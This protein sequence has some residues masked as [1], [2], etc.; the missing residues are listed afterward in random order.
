MFN[1]KNVC[2]ILLILL[3]FS[4]NFFL[5]QNQQLK[6]NV[7]WREPKAIEFEGNDFLIPDF[8]GAEL[9]HGRPVL[10]RSVKL[11][12]ASHKIELVNYS[13]A[14]STK[15]DLNFLNELDVEVSDQLQC[16]FQVTEAG[17]ENFAVVHLF[18]FIRENNVLKRINSIEFEILTVPQLVNTQ[19][20][21]FALTSVLKE[22][23]GTWFKISVKN[24]AIYKIDKAFL[25]SCGINTNGLNPDHINIYGNGD[26]KL[27]ELNSI[28]RTDD[29]AKNAIYIQGDS[30]GS[31]DDGDYILFYGWGPHRWSPTGAT[32]FEQTRNV[33]SD[34]SCYFININTND[35]PLRIENLQESAGPATH[36]ITSYSYFDIYENDLVSLVK[37]GQRW[38]GELFDT[39]L[40][41]TFNFSV[42]N[43]VSSFAA[44]FKLAIGTNARTS[45]GTLQRY[46][47]NG[48]LLEESNLPAVSIDY[49]RDVHSL[50]WTN[51]TSSMAFKINI[52]RNNPN[53]LV[54]LDRI[55]LNA[56]RN[57]VF[58]GSQ[59]KF[60]DLTSFGTGNIGEFQISSFPSSGFVWDI[61]NRHHP[62]KIEG[63]SLSMGV[64]TFNQEIDTL[65]EFCVSN[66]LSFQIPD[67]VGAVA[68]QDL[69]ALPQAELLIVT[70]KD[71][72][73]QA[74]RLAD[75]H[76]G[77][78]LTVNV[79]TTE[80]VFNEFSS[81]AVDATAIR[82]FAKMFYDRGISIPE[83]RLRNLLLF[84]DGTFDPKN[85]VAN[86]NYFIPT[87]QVELSE[88]HIGAMVTDD[89]FALLSDSDGIGATDM[90]D[91]GVGRLLISDNNIARQQ[92][93]KIQHYMKNGSNL[94]NTTTTNCCC[95][96]NGNSTTFGDWRLNYV[97]IADDEEGGYFIHQDTEPQYDTVS[98]Y[99]PEMNC[100][101]LYTDA[102]VQAT[103]AGGQRY[104]DVFEA[105]TNRVER[106]ALVVNYVGHGGE[107]GLAEE[108][109]VTI[110]QVQGWQNIDRLNVFVSAT[111]EFTKYD[112]PSRV[113][114]GE[115]VSLN[116][117]GGAIV[118]MT[119]SRSVYFGVNTITGKRFFQ[120]VFKRDAEDR[121]REFG[122]I[123]MLTKNGSGS[124]DNKRSF[125][126]IG[127]PALRIALPEM[128]IVTDSINGLSPS[129][130]ID[131]LQAL[132]KVTIKGHIEDFNGNPI[133]DFNG[134][135]SPSV[136]DKPK[137]QNTLGQD[138]NSPVIPFRVQR[139]IVYK[140]KSSVTNGYFEF[141]FVVPKDI[142]L[143]F[144]NGKISYYGENG[145]F[146]ASGSD[147]TFI[148][149]GI[150]P[151]GVND[152]IGPDITLYLNENNFVNGGITDETPMLV[153]E[154][155]DE[156]G[157]NTVGNGIG[158][159]LTAVID[160]NSA[161]PIV[162]NE[163]YVADLDSYQSGSVRYTLPQLTKGKHTLTLKVWDVNNNSSE[164]TIDFIVQEKETI[165]LDH[166]LNYPNPFTTYTEF[167]FEHNQVCSE[168]E[169]QVQIMTVSGKLV[170]TINQ[171]VNTQGFRSAGIPW[172][173]K[174]DFG[175]QLAKGVY[176]Y[177]IK[178][179]TPEGEIAEKLEK[180]VLLK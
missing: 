105:I 97:Q 1:L 25:E 130:I 108:R 49:V 117:Y 33:Y 171:T 63:S 4:N 135:L 144:G 167:F 8:E 68:Y 57:L 53:V 51:P 66:G 139:N 34:V 67:R 102:Y 179:K 145:D 124:S 163:Y 149:G 123:M 151:N 101:K 142:N 61:T 46:T 136:F 140:G 28:S 78:G 32:G 47:V 104:P 77:E 69:H 166:V 122:E 137:I 154:L 90:M 155:F 65:R 24:D 168:L 18:P 178:V 6:L 30:D 26:G 146:D 153:A 138:P 89:Y 19:T 109:I 88:N 180:L 54:Y 177:W 134:T 160:A 48:V 170:K 131:T 118:L 156:N 112:D 80:Q 162:L 70:H 74:N 75:L 45:S 84:G 126:L 31:F 119:T 111:C 147:T 159:D 39:E 71:F 13:T 62:K 38:Y 29:L 17:K 169:A 164:E 127:D 41:R 5:A 143:S 12:N 7:E 81:G 115:W 9:D 52:T 120:N 73:A 92:V 175:D 55:V 100:D 42:P 3:N 132:S 133:T 114:A 86:N 176:L 161:D 173:G 64:F 148:I 103:S 91:I 141:S 27:P 37:G 150:D 94:Y 98:L 110:P 40:E 116:P 35:T 95:D 121:P 172:D 36:T 152:Q 59:M 21:D 76:R 165:T 43:I 60:R 16:E 106:G 113:S 82:M 87:Y 56:R 50:N 125:T 128:R 96:A 83:N 2:F 79:A 99:H 157:I 14:P 15:A 20:K 10:F 11:K 129:I 85:R 93:D 23:S 174:D 72:I 107:V 58:Y 158:H 22:G 44:N